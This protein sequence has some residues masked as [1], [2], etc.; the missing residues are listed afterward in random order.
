[1]QFACRACTARSLSGSEGPDKVSCVPQAVSCAVQAHP[2]GTFL[3]PLPPTFTSVSSPVLGQ[4]PWAELET[5]D[6]KIWLTGEAV[7]YEES[8]STHQT[9]S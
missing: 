5:S 3:P 6:L 8:H 4:M 9:N 2:W 1:M 7:K